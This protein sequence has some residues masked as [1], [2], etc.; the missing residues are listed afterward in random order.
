MHS[1]GSDEI[2]NC[3][4]LAEPSLLGFA[5]SSKIS[6]TI[7]MDKK[8]YLKDLINLALDS[9]SICKVSSRCCLN[10]LREAL[11]TDMNLS[12]STFNWFF[13]PYNLEEIIKST[14]KVSTKATFHKS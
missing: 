8:T 1:K 4:G 10:C 9:L 3:T 13:R 12:N 11:I 2:I 6:L 7:S 14:E 5:I